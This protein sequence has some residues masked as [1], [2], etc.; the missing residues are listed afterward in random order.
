MKKIIYIIIAAVVLFGIYKLLSIPP[1]STPTSTPITETVQENPDLILYWGIGCP[2]CEK[3]KEWII[4]NNADQKLKINQKEVYQNTDNQ[5]ELA[6]VVSQNCP[7][8]NQGGVGVPLGFDPINKKC[9]S[10]DQPIIDFLS[11]KVK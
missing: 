10:G 11:Q 2:H 7:E 3:V 1:K 4:A 8:L 9:I 6:D 5:K